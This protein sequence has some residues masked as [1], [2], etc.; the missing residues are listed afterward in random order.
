MRRYTTRLHLALLAALVGILATSLLAF[1]SVQA[2][3]E[4]S[5]GSGSMTTP[6][7]VWSNVKGT[8]NSPLVSN[9]NVYSGEPVFLEGGGFPTSSLTSVGTVAVLV[10]NSTSSNCPMTPQGTLTSGVTVLQKFSSADNSLSVSQGAFEVSFNIPSVTPLPKQISACAYFTSFA[11]PNAPTLTS[12]QDLAV[13]ATSAP[14][15]A[16]P[17]ATTIQ[18]SQ[19]F[20]I[21]GDH[22][23]TAHTV[24]IT[25]TTSAGTPLPSGSPVVVGSNGSFT[26]KISAPTTTGTYTIAATEDGGALIAK[27]TFSVAKN[28]TTSTTPGGGG[29]S[30][31][32]LVAPLF[33]VIVVLFLLMLAILALLVWSGRS[34]APTAGGQPEGQPGAQG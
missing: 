13:V 27:T 4:G 2:Q 31:T 15:L 16:I 14:T 19:S 11:S 20:T 17:G 6:T 7:L 34:G 12:S 22:W 18:P 32:G 9:P 28:A 8:A 23:D 25:L 1:G 21:T 5:M 24:T 29:S 26:E 10:I 30:L 3:A 33:Y